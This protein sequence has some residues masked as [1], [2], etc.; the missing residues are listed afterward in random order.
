MTATDYGVQRADGVKAV[1]HMADGHLSVTQNGRTIVDGGDYFLDMPYNGGVILD[2]SK[3]GCDRSFELPSEW[4]GR[5]T[6]KGEIWTQGKPVEI[7][8]KGNRV[9]IRLDAGDSLVLKRK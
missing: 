9:H 8:A 4:K 1:V 2:Y 6:L 7:P 5:Q 3:H